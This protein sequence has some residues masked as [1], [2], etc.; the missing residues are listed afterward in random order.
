[1]SHVPV[2]V[3]E[4]ADAARKTKIVDEQ[5]GLLQQGQALFDHMAAGCTFNPGFPRW[6]TNLMTCLVDFAIRI[7]A[8]PTPQRANLVSPGG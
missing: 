4:N 5:S 6:V 2:E 3:A 1:M 8:I 7:N